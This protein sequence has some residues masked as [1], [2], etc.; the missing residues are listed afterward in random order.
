MSIYQP[1]ALPTLQTLNEQAHP[2]S[3]LTTPSQQA[4]AFVKHEK[5]FHLGMLPTEMSNPA[6]ANLSTVFDENIEDGVKMLLSVDA[7]LVNALERVLTS[8]E[9]SKLLADIVR[10]VTSGGRVYLTGCGATGR[11]S[12]LL[13]ASWRKYWQQLREQGKLSQADATRYEASMVSVISGGDYALIRSVE[14]F[15]D[16]AT[17]GWHQLNEHPISDKDLVIAI[18][19]GGETS[20]VIGAAWRGVEAGASVCFVFNNPKEILCEHVARSRDLINHD[21]VVSLDLSAGPMAVAGST[22]MQATTMEQIA[23][24]SAIELAIAEIL[25]RHMSTIDADTQV[26]LAR[27]PTDYLNEYRQLIHDLSADKSCAGMATAIKLESD[28]YRPGGYVTYAA[29]EYLLDILTDTTERAPTFCLPPFKKQNHP[30]AEESWA[31]AKNPLHTTTT[32][33]KRMLG[34]EIRALEWDAS[35]YASLDISEKLKT[36]PPKINEAEILKF[37]IGTENGNART[38]GPTSCLVACLAGEELRDNAPADAEFVAKYTA[39][40]KHYSHCALLAIGSSCADKYAD[41]VI[42]IPCGLPETPMRLWTHIAVKLVFNCLSTGT[43]VMMGRVMGNWMVFAEATNKKLIDR[44]TRIV[45]ELAQISY[46]DACDALHVAIS[47]LATTGDTS[48]RTT[49]PAA[50]ALRKLG[51]IQ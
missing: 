49:S 28:T 15:E 22:R 5:A 39:M 46:E 18:T 51:V 4:D 43:M 12:I 26:M 30:E 48:S 50:T 32:T 31:F 20:F 21:S 8:E 2:M 7:A 44:G 6:T 19:E 45:S 17:I 34:R 29:D 33:W 23:V 36:S 37:T 42:N 3:T 13:E 38:Q 9:Y 40:S 11:L 27:T 10:V 1:P 14:G 25:K 47:E 41:Q 16:F 35:R 24:G